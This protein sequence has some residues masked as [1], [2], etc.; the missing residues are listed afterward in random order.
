MPSD[1]IANL[2]QILSTSLNPDGSINT[3][4][5]VELAQAY[6]RGTSWYAQT[7]PGI[8]Q[9][10][11]AGLF[12][13]ESGYMA[14][15]NQVN[16]IY[17]QY[18]GRPATSAE[19]NAHITSGQ[20]VSQISNQFQ[21]G[22]IQQNF[23]DPLKAIFTTSELQA[24]ANEQAGIDTALGQKISAEANLFT[25]VNQLY[26][27]F[28]GTGVTRAQLD[29]LTSQG[30]DAATVAQQFAVQSNINAMNPAI[31]D[32]FTPAEIQQI[33]L[34]AAGGT[35]QNGKQL[36]DLANL[37]TQLNPIYHEE[38]GNGLSRD[39]LNS[40]YSSGYTPTQIQNQ[41]QG[42]NYAAANAP[43]IQQ[44]EGSFGTG[45]LSATDLQTLGQE[46]S[47]FDTPQGQVLL[48]AYQKA[49]QRLAGAF[50]GTLANP[51]VTAL[52]SAGAPKTPDVGAV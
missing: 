9:G 35:T 22:A 51:S 11:D 39:E 30:T 5:A 19:L 37:A 28:Y 3:S 23:S 33:A 27:N 17:Q 41:L 50:K 31:A 12:N 40:A 20:S 10:I 45:Q 32:L 7:Y 38:T 4:E 2:N 47:G 43:D 14:Y 49:Q 25:G 15:E 46:A 42:N 6:V 13:D 21:S 16:Q 34:E 8:Q 26:E 52:L 29:Q 18:W 44:T 36:T 24:F 1:V 48:T